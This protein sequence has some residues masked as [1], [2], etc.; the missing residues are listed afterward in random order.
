MAAWTTDEPS[1]PL[2][3]VVLYLQIPN[4]NDNDTWTMMMPRSACGSL[5]TDMLPKLVQANDNIV[6]AMY[7]AVPCK[8][9]VQ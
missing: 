4:T 5:C 6:N 1:V 2:P 3:I 9:K 8:L 7:I